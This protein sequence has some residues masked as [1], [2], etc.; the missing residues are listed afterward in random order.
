[1]SPIETII[2]VPAAAGGMQ[3]VRCAIIAG[4]EWRVSEKD[5]LELRLPQLRLL[6]LDDPP[7]AD[8]A[9]VGYTL[10]ELAGQLF[11]GTEWPDYL[12]HETIP[13]LAWRVAESFPPRFCG[14]EMRPRE[15]AV[16]PIIQRK[17]SLRPGSGFGE[18]DWN[19]KAA[20]RLGTLAGRKL[21]RAELIEWLDD[22]IV[23]E[24]NLSGAMVLSALRA[25]GKQQRPDYF[26]DAD[27]DG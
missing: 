12:D 17:P 20:Y 6:R 9:A 23:G 13:N 8:A 1:M 22:L 16:L 24:P 2:H 11:E 3:A 25:M 26:G 7:A 10:D 21:E 5:G 18:D 4:S 14:E 27:V 15:T 19:L